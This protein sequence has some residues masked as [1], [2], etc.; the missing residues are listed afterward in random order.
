MD[1]TIDLRRALAWLEPDAPLPSW[2][3]RLHVIAVPFAVAA[4]GLLVARTHDGGARTAAAVYAAG[5]VGLFA[6]SAAYHSRRWT[7]R[8]FRRMRLLDHAMIFVLIGGT[9]TA[10]S[11]TT[12]HGAARAALL[13]AVWTGGAVGTA[14]KFARPEA[15][16]SRVL[17]GVLYIALGWLA[18]FAVPSL[19]RQ[20]GATIA[21]LVVTGGLLYTLGALVLHRRRPDPK[22][23]RFGYH[24]IWHSMV[25]AAAAC[26]CVALF[27]LFRTP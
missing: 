17:G 2:R 26:H 10:V 15:R 14:F 5:L 20:A 25:V 22:P 1:E 23:Q 11:A 4:A 6:T 12:L 8:G 16:S 27:L 24:E 7:E 9:A 18:I 3:G 21:G 19:F 13:A